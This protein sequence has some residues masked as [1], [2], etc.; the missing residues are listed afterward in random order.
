M[1]GKCFCNLGLAYQITND[2][3]NLTGTDGAARQVEMF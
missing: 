3:K 1:F 2:I